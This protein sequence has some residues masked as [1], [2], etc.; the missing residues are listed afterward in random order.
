MRI[1]AIETRSIPPSLH[2]FSGVGGK[3]QEF[4]P[5]LR[6]CRALQRTLRLV[7]A[8]QGPTLQRNGQ[9]SHWFFC[10]GVQLW[11]NRVQS[12]MFRYVTIIWW[13]YRMW[14]PYVFY[15]CLGWRSLDLHG[16]RRCCCEEQQLGRARQISPGMIS[17]CRQIPRSFSWPLECLLAVYIIQFCFT[18]LIHFRWLIQRLLVGNSCIFLRCGSRLYLYSLFHR[19]GFW[20]LLSLRHEIILLF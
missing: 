19:Y 10:Q 5:R 16:G 15:F 1:V 8:G 13:L 7:P 9:R 20:S 11:N 6:V 12:G 2:S 3:H 14:I 17:H 18:L 4:G